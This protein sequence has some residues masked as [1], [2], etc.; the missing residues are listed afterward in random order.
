VIGLLGMSI[1]FFL[2]QR[3]VFADKIIG[4]YS[5]ELSTPVTKEI[6][7]IAKSSAQGMFKRDLFNWTQ[8]YL[9]TVWDTSNPMQ[10]HHF[11]SF[12]TLS[13]KEA[14]E[15]SSFEDHTWNLTYSLDSDTLI[16]LLKLHNDQSDELA[17]KCWKAFVEAKKADNF[18]SQYTFGIK[19]I[20]YAMGHIGSKP[21]E[22]P[23][24]PGTGLLSQAQRE[25]KTLL[26]RFSVKSSDVIAGKPGFPPQNDP[27]VT[28]M[29][30]SLPFS[31]MRFSAQLASGR[32]IAEGKTDSKGVFSLKSIK[33]PY[34]QTSTFL[35]IRS[36]PAAE[37]DPTV[38]FTFS[39]MGLALTESFEQVLIFK[40]PRPTFTLEYDAKSVSDLTIHD[41]FSNSKYMIGFL[42]DS[43]Y[44]KHTENQ[45]E[46]DLVFVINCQ[47]SRYAH[48]ATESNMV[49][50]EANITITEKSVTPPNVIE[51]VFVF[52][53]AYEQGKDIPV[54]EFTW[55]TS[56]RLEQKVK[57]TLEK[58]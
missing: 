41:N 22:I 4:K 37:I 31:G 51:D 6:S 27:Q 12:V 2:S 52:E 17:L 32:T 18:S 48:D 8:E 25:M 19:T 16:S 55:D 1:L 50:A 38:S 58:L 35:Y 47:I 5:I 46:A 36:N 26:D 13:L 56:K 39:D 53:K 42:E 57:Q 10:R 28:V 43:C 40:V 30:D 23:G 9:A 24:S 15:K 44:L 14:K 29:I 11:N 45:A 21:P 49:K 33:I 7:T 34:V 3:S 20:Y 54:G